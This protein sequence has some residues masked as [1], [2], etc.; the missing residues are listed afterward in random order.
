MCRKAAAWRRLE[1][2]SHGWPEPCPLWRDAQF[3]TDILRLLGRAQDWRAA[4]KASPERF[5]LDPKTLTAAA[6]MQR[7][8]PLREAD[9]TL[10][11]EGRRMRSP[12]RNC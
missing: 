10:I 6:E 9:L 7:E 11:A 4:L 5:L 3:E 1:C 12:S 8:T 2:S